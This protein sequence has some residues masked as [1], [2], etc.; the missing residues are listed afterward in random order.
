MRFKKDF[1]YFDLIN[2]N[3]YEHTFGTSSQN[4]SVWF[5]FDYMSKTITKWSH[6]LLMYFK[7]NNFFG[8]R[9]VIFNKVYYSWTVTVDSLKHKWYGDVKKP[10]S[11]KKF[12]TDQIV[13]LFSAYTRVCLIKQHHSVEKWMKWNESQCRKRKATEDDLLST[14]IQKINMINKKCK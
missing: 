9:V 14:V 12:R 1:T 4:L 8:I 10:C 7:Q 11:E 5:S 13:N 2:V 3:K 6:H